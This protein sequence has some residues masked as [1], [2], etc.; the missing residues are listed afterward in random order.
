MTSRADVPVSVS[1][2]GNY[3]GAV[4]RFLAYAVDLGVS[5]AVFT[6]ALAGVG[7]VVQVITGKP[8]HW[9]RS[10]TIVAVLYVVWQFVYFGYS[11]AVASRTFGMYVLGLRVVRA[12]GTEIAARQGVVRAL[13]FPLSFL[14]FGLGFLGILFQHEHRALHDL[15]AGTTVIYSWDA[16]AA[17]L[18][19]LARESELTGRPGA[20]PPVTASGGAAGGAALDGQARPDGAVTPR[21]DG[22]GTQAAPSGG[23]QAAPS[24]GTQAAPG[25][26]AR[27]PG[28]SPGTPRP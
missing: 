11:W 4:S 25:G 22:G 10:D 23:T 12:D 3:A 14:L 1:A 21:A 20:P 5:S 2:Q 24:G 8:V 7:F 27:V 18:H 19:F 9:T 6:L 16:R 13:V 15:I 26:D 28:G 17:H